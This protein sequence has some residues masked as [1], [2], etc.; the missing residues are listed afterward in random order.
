[1]YNISSKLLWYAKRRV[2][3]KVWNRR[4][5]LFKTENQCSLQ[6][7]SS[8]HPLHCVEKATSRLMLFHH[9]AF[10]KMQLIFSMSKNDNMNLSL[11]F[12]AGFLLAFE[13]ICRFQLLVRPYAAEILIPTLGILVSCLT[14]AAWICI[15][16]HKGQSGTKLYEYRSHWSS[17]HGFSWEST[18]TVVIS[19]TLFGDD[20]T[21]LIRADCF[22]RTLI[23]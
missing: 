6:Q 5:S 3:S 1:M 14:K 10:V 7:N 21:P 17:V 4:I 20:Y 13:Y 15:G 12:F 16:G 19:K 9:F 8:A 22:D 18:R 2:P 23:F 11:M